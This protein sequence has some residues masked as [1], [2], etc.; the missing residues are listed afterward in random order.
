MTGIKKSVIKGDSGWN[1]E[2]PF[3]VEHVRGGSGV[4]V[5]SYRK[6]S[7]GFIEIWGKFY[8]QNTGAGQVASSGRLN[9]PIT[10]TDYETVHVNAD[11]INSTSSYELNGS[12]DRDEETWFRYMMS[13]KSTGSPAP[14]N[15]VELAQYYASGF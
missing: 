12:C 6:W 9:F 13:Y 4:T 14:S 15:H 1:S 3:V 11:L 10:F 5:W 2:F 8:A 7:N